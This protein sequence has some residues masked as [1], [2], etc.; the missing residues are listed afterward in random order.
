[1]KQIT[2]SIDENGE[3]T[4]DLEGYQGKGCDAALKDLTDPGDT[5]LKKRVKPAYYQDARQQ[6]KIRQ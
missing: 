6:E 4:V 1:M 5:V 2:I 3:T